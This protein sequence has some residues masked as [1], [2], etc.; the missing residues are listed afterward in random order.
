MLQALHTVESDVRVATIYVQYTEV[1]GSVHS[2]QSTA[3]LRCT[4]VQLQVP[5]EEVEA[6]TYVLSF[7]GKIVGK[8]FQIFLLTWFEHTDSLALAACGTF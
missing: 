7:L 3:L 6:I 1:H 4:Y 8:H 2:S 5:S